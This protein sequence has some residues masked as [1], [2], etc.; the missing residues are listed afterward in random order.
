M[1]TAVI[2]TRDC[3]E[4]FLARS[5]P[6]LQFYRLAVQ[7]DGTDLKVHANGADIAL[8]IRV[9]GEA[10]QQTRFADTGVPD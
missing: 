5:V 3:P 2:R 1:S 9:V 4:P 6:D 7:I 10:Q 8:R